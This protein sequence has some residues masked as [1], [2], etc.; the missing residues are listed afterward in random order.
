MNA[1]TA[2][3]NTT[4]W[5]RCSSSGS[6]PRGRRCGRNRRERRGS[7]EP[8]RGSP[9]MSRARFRPHFGHRVIVIARA[10][11]TAT[12]SRTRRR[13][14]PAPVT[15]QLDTTVRSASFGPA[16]RSAGQAAS[17]PAGRVVPASGCLHPPE[18]R[19]PRER[20]HAPRPLSSPAK[21]SV[22]SIPLVFAI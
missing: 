21:T 16:F 13:A 7:R 14:E 2:P 10:A 6:G 19:H 8:R 15:A 22:T 20:C 1:A 18:P 4:A 12:P 11:P 5:W 17:C 3:T 9:T